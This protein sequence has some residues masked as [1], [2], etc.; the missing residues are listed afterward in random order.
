MLGPVRASRSAMAA[1]DSPPSALLRRPR[2]SSGDVRAAVTMSN[3]PSEPSGL[4][5]TTGLT[6]G[7]ATLERAGGLLGYDLAV[8]HLDDPV[9]HPGDNVVVGHQHDRHPS[10]LA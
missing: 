10:F 6:M 3:V 1:P 9:R 8:E 4:A 5:L 7:R 2:T